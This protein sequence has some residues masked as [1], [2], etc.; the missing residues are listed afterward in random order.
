[1]SYPKANLGAIVLP[2]PEAGEEYDFEEYKDFFGIDLLDVFKKKTDDYYSIR[3]DLKKPVFLADIE[4]NDKSIGSLFS[5]NAYGRETHADIKES[6]FISLI[7]DASGDANS[8]VGITL[9]ST[10]SVKF[11]EL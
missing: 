5:I 4:G 10:G 3:L 1:M 7:F 9:T 11:W 6:H 8:G 2:L